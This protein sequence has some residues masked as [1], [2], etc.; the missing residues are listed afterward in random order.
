MAHVNIRIDESIKNNAESVFSNLGITP[1][2]AITL[3]YVQVARTNSI[4]FELKA[5][6]PNS[7]TIKAI[8][9]VEK[10]KKDKSKGFK[11]ME[12]LKKSLDL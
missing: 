6:I 9:Q 11:D 8:K 4:P 2:A 10:L 3:F 7:K 5:E 1:T 12:S